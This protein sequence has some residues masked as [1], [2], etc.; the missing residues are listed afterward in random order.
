MT[1][2][3]LKEILCLKKASIPSKVKKNELVSMATS[4][5]MVSPKARSMIHMLTNRNTC[6]KTLKE[7]LVK[8]SLF[9]LQQIAL[10]TSSDKPCVDSC[11]AVEQ[12]VDSILSK[13]QSKADKNTPKISKKERIEKAR[14]NVRQ[15]MMK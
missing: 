14:A 9:D 6:T 15:R 10:H 3:K 4:S 13:Y 5:I 1:V 12:L 2:K 11:T 7:K 8:F